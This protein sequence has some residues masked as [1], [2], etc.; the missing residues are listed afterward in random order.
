MIINRKRIYS[1]ILIFLLLTPKNSNAI[2]LLAVSLIALKWSPVLLVPIG[3]FVWRGY[4]Q[5]RRLGLL[6]NNMQEDIDEI[7]KDT[8]EIKNGVREVKKDT[9]TINTKVTQLQASVANIDGKVTNLQTVVDGFEKKTGQNFTDVRSDI[10]ETKVTLINELSSKEKI[11]SDL[12]K[13]TEQNL[14]Q[15]AQ[16]NYK[17]L[18]TQLDGIKLEIKTLATKEDV[19]DLKDFAKVIDSKLDSVK[20]QLV[21]SIK[22][23]ESS[24]K[25]YFKEQLEEKFVKLDKSVDDKFNVLRQFLAKLEQKQNELDGGVSRINQNIGNLDFKVTKMSNEVGEVRNIIVGNRV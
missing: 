3:G 9:E 5:L 12:I 4:N 7:K 1:I 13:S 10:S 6:S 21:I 20:D 16:D 25:M 24:N 14:K 19:K 2:G 15:D 11:L 17:N 22:Q 8:N 18:V 23:S